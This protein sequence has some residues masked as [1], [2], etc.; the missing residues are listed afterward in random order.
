MKL[1]ER[2]EYEF[3]AMDMGNVMHRA[4]ENFAEEVR[5][6][7]LNWKELTPESREK[8]LQMN[9]WMRSWRITGIRF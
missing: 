6:K 4:L 7:G 5:K 1:T 9:V 3:K 2:V 8:R